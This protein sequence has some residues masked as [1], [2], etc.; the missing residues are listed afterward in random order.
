MLLCLPTRNMARQPAPAR[1]RQRRLDVRCPTRPYQKRHTKD[2]LW[3][4]LYAKSEHQPRAKQVRLEEG[5]EPGRT[6]IQQGGLAV[7]DKDIFIRGCNN[8]IGN[9]SYELVQKQ[10]EGVKMTPPAMATA[11]SSRRP[12]WACSCTSSHAHFR[13]SSARARNHRFGLLSAPH[14]HTN[15][16]HRVDLL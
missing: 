16:P 7:G 13:R 15:A 6:A 4:T 2:L 5:H 8:F 14:V 1:A 3:K 12:W 9:S 10:E 11:S